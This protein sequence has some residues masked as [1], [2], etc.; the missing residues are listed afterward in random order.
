MDFYGVSFYVCWAFVGVY[1]GFVMD[2]KSHKEINVYS[3]K[4]VTK[5]SSNTLLL[6]VTFFLEQT[7]HMV[8]S[9]L[10]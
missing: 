9:I 5:C 8:S 4:K 10:P 3:E 2:R 1:K 7:L 6:L